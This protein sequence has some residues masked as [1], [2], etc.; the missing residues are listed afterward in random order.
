MLEGI[1][2][3]VLPPFPGCLVPTAD[4]KDPQSCPNRVTPEI[5]GLSYALNEKT[6]NKCAF[7]YAIP[8]A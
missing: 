8:S 5:F 7:P 2:L 3:V 6:F 1:S 4:L